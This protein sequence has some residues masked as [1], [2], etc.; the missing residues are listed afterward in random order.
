MFVHFRFRPYMLSVR[1]EL[2]F[3]Y[4]RSTSSTWRSATDLTLLGRLRSF[5]IEKAAEQSGTGR[6]AAG[7]CGGS[8]SASAFPGGGSKG[9]AA[10]SPKKKVPDSRPGVLAI[11]SWTIT[12]DRAAGTVTVEGWFISPIPFSCCHSKQQN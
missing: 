1:A 8:P 12:I 2:L 4:M 10:F 9:R 3:E 11:K 6:S 5:I 7:A